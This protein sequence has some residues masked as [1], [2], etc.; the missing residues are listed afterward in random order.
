MTEAEP[1]SAAR[2]GILENQHSRMIGFKTEFR[3]AGKLFQAARTLGVEDGTPDAVRALFEQ[4]GRGE[5]EFG[6]VASI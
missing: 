5:R 1:I 3:D 2:A 6:E 4:S